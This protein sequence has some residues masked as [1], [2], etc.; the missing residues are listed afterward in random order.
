MDGQLPGEHFAVLHSFLLPKL[1]DLRSFS[2]DGSDGLAVLPL[3]PDRPIDSVS[4]KRAQIIEFS[5]YKASQYSK[6]FPRPLRFFFRKTDPD[7]NS[8]LGMRVPKTKKV[9][10]SFTPN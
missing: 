1:N 4:V 6:M 10:V 8:C 5:S 9:K 7:Q 2:R 3:E